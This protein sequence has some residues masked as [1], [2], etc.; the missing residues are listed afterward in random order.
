MQNLIQGSGT[1]AAGQSLTSL[2][3]SPSASGRRA[4]RRFVTAYAYRVTG[5]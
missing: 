3:P 4:G 5:R 1:V 2:W